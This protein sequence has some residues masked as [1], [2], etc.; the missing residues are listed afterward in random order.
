MLL[1][2][3]R[4]NNDTSPLCRFSI[5]TYLRATHGHPHTSTLAPPTYSKLA[6]NLITLTNPHTPTQ[7]EEAGLGSQHLDDDEEGAEDCCW[8]FAD[9]FALATYVGMIVIMVLNFDLFLSR[10]G[11]GT[12]IFT[13]GTASQQAREVS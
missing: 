3:Q 12:G 13:L 10:W 9:G 1:N 6:N 2:R 8:G 5:L 4:L 11:V 7:D